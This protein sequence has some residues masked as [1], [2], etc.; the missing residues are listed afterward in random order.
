MKTLNKAHAS[1]HENRSIETRGLVELY[2]GYYGAEGQ[3][4]IV[5]LGRC[6]LRGQGDTYIA[7][8]LQTDEKSIR[9]QCNEGNFPGTD[10]ILCSNW[11]SINRSEF[12]LVPVSWLTHEEPA[13]AAA[14][15]KSLFT[16]M[17]EYDSAV[18]TLLALKPGYD[19][20]HEQFINARAA[21]GAALA[22]HKDL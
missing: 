21:L 14:V 13:P 8:I 9:V 1:Q 11:D 2:S 3:L 15:E 19:A 6:W 18:A 22:K 12:Y 16:I 10:N 5:K 17:C 7:R 20:A 4:V